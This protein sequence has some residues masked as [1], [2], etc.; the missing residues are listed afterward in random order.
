MSY[1]LSIILAVVMLSACGNSKKTSENTVKN[2]TSQVEDQNEDQVIQQE[3]EHQII[4]EDVAEGDS[5]FA[6]IR[7]GYC[8]GQCQV[9]EMH[10]Y[11]SGYVEYNGIANVSLLGKHRTNIK[12]EQMIAFIDKANEIGYMTMDDEY[13][14]PMISDLPETK[15]SLVMNLKRKSMRRRYGYPRTVLEFEKLFE[16]LIA[17]EKWDVLP[18]EKE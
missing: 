8:F 17:S 9:F 1:F 15:T 12:K 14:N 5:L 6:F 4:F 13:D 18:T 10:I 2:E 7:K 16:N 3:P 11:N